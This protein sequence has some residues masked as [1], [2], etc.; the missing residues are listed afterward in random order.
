MSDESPWRMVR[1]QTACVWC[2]CVVA[3]PDPHY[4][5]C[6][7]QAARREHQQMLKDY[8]TVFPD[9]GKDADAQP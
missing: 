8:E 7:G 6:P 3:L 1:G 9:L 2:G 4:A 5:T